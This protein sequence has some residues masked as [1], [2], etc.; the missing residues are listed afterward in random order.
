MRFLE[1]YPPEYI[2]GKESGIENVFPQVEEHEPEEPYEVDDEE[3]EL[4]DHGGRFELDLP[5][6][7]KGQFV[8]AFDGSVADVGYSFGVLECGRVAEQF[9]V[10]VYFEDIAVEVEDEMGEVLQFAE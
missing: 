2:F 10:E 8:V 7:E 3:V 9:A 4:I 6:V 1:K 5:V